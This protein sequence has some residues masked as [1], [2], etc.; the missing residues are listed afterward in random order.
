MQ[1][2]R[3]DILRHR[4]GFP[5]ANVK[6]DDYMKKNHVLLIAAAV[7]LSS[8]GTA[9]Q[10]ASSGDGYRFQDGI[11]GS[12]PSLTKKADAQEQKEATDALV[13]KTKASEIYLF[14]DRKDTVMIPKNM[15]ATI[16]YDGLGGGTSV[17]IT[18]NPYDWRNNIDPWGW[19]GPSV[20]LNYGWGYPRD[21]AYRGWYSP[22]YGGWHSSWGYGWYD[23]WYYPGGWY[24]PWY[25]GYWGW[26]DPWCSWHHHYCGWY[27]GWD[28]PFHGGTIIVK[29]SRWRGPRHSTGSDRVFTTRTSSRAGIATGTRGGRGT[30]AS[31]APSTGKTQA[32]TR[33]VSRT[34]TSRP[35]S[36]AV[37]TTASRVT[38]PSRGSHGQAVSSGSSATARRPVTPAGR[39]ASAASSA[40]SSRPAYNYRRPASSGHSS[41]SSVSSGRSS[42][43]RGTSYGSSSSQSSSQ[44]SYNRRSSSQS[45]YNR[46]GSSA[47]SRS[48]YS[49]GSSSG[50]RS[51]SS[52]GGY[53]RSGGSGGGRR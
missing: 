39:P 32:A 26:H 10:Y 40:S 23:P 4:S 31:G 8:C 6:E 30:A 53:S 33:T 7:M 34:A 44:S 52:G 49:G 20:S 14:G 51:G 50:S 16:T 41:G 3:I 29:D 38:V 25:G 36:S 24:D 17:T 35:S 43:S 28:P 12:T 1:N 5:G 19:Y 2:N 15:S 47:P 13:A 11:Y 37:R 42:Y 21:W 18:D 27:G 48:S 9:A 45:S 46:S 22:W